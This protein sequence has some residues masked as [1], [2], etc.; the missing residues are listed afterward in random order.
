MEH[1]G[2]E[3]MVGETASDSLLASTLV[4]WGGE[5]KKKKRFHCTHCICPQVNFRS[6]H[7]P[8]H[9]WAVKVPKVF[10]EFGSYDLVGKQYLCPM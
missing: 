1:I 2:L 9:P 7:E 10:L 5:K 4:L 6:D 3:I 8:T